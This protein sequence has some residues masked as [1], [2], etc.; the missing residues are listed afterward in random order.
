MLRNEEELIKAVGEAYDEYLREKINQTWL[1]LQC[2]FNQ[3]IT[4]HSDNDYCIDHIVKEKLECNGN[5]PDVM[6]VVDDA[7]HL[8]NHND[9]DDDESENEITYS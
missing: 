6:D 1:T 3:I 2:C 4:H 8:L 7:E 5:L 9:M